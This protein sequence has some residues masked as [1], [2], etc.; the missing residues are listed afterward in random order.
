M[1][2]IETEIQALKLEAAKAEKA[3]WQLRLEHQERDGK[4]WALGHAHWVRVPGG[5]AFSFDVEVRMEPVFTA[6]V[7]ATPGWK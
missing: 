4:T 5:E 6:K 2:P 3:Y 1:S 7:D